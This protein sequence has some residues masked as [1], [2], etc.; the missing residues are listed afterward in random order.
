MT[1]LSSILSRQIHD[2]CNLHC[3]APGHNSEITPHIPWSAS[4]DCNEPNA[5]HDRGVKRP[6]CLLWTFS[7]MFVMSHYNRTGFCSVMFHK[8][9]AVLHSGSEMIEV[10]VSVNMMRFPYIVSC[11]LHPLTFSPLD[12]WAH[13]KAS[14]CLFEWPSGTSH[15]ALQHWLWS[16]C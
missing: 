2:F 4:N 8:E 7:S 11:F 6:V 15:A 3:I 13:R 1:D 12:L 16:H 10:C 9:P 14:L 5:M